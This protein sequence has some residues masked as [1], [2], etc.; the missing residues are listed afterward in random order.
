MLLLGALER[1]PKQAQSSCQRRTI[2][3]TRSPNSDTSAGTPRWS[4]T[5][6]FSDCG[7]MPQHPQF[8][9]SPGLPVFLDVSPGKGGM[10]ELPGNQLRC[11]AR[12]ESGVFHS[13]HWTKK[14]KEEASGGLWLPSQLY[15]EQLR[16][17]VYGVEF[18][19]LSDHRSPFS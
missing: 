5:S 15:R 9:L 4:Q 2:H 16:C 13:S 14:T 18:Y 12:L 11:F 8:I 3:R 7:Q 19:C 6:G 10:N 17:A 1:C